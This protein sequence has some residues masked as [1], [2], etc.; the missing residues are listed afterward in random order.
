MPITF[1]KGGNGGS[2]LLRWHTK[3]AELKAKLKK[4]KEHPD[5][6]AEKAL[7]AEIDAFEKELK[8]TAPERIVQELQDLGK[9]TLSY[10][11]R[12]APRFPMG[13]IVVTRGVDER[14]E[15][16]PAFQEFVSRSLRR[17][18]A[19]DWGDMSPEDKKAND[20]ALKEGNRLMSAYEQKPFPKIWII[21]EWDRSVTTVLFPEEY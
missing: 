3:M 18:R 2:K 4:I 19:G 11:E 7:I 17:H 5:V 1:G 10:F 8:G 12:Y 13:H 16:D 6:E 14:G 15:T 9:V 20:A 21:T